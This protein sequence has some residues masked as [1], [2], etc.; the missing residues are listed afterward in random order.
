MIKD[1]T[2]RHFDYVSDKSF[3]EVVAAFEASTG[4]IGNGAF[5]MELAASADQEDF[6]RR[7]HA[8]EADTG[9]MRFLMLDHGA[10]GALMGSP[11]KARLYDLGNPLIARTMARHNIAAAES[12]PVR[13]LIFETDDGR[14]HLTYKLPSSLMAHLGDPLITAAAQK[15]DAKLASFAEQIT[16]VRA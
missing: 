11:T 8:Y 13:L 9:F 12:V 16:G 15:L 14:T 1:F 7:V 6:A 2:V 10:L 3:E 5:A 4:D